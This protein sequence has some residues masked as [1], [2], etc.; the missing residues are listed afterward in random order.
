MTGEGGVALRAATALGRIALDR[1]D[2]LRGRALPRTAEQLA[3]PRM[4]DEL[5]AGSAPPDAPPLP[6]LRRAR[7][8]GVWFESSNCTNF[9]IEV[10]F[11]SA[12]GADGLRLP[13]TLYAKLPPPNV[14][15]RAFANAMGFWQAEVLFCRRLAARVPVATPRVYAAAWRGARFV[16]LLENLHERPGT[17]LFI[18]RDMAAGSTPERSRA[19]L[20]ALARLH[21]AFWST[22]PH[23]RDALL[24]MRLHA[25][26]APG[27]R[28]RSRALAE[29][30]IGPCHRKV[31]DLFRAEHVA[32]C[33]RALAKWDRLV[34]AWYAEPLTLLHGDSHLANCFEHPAT[35][36]SGTAVGL[37][38]FQGVHWGQGVRDVQYHLIDSL[39]P[40]VLAACER[41]LVDDYVAALARH[42]VTLESERALEQYRVLSFQTLVVAMV[43][44]GLGSLTEREDTVRT[45]LRRSVAA[46]ERLGFADRLDAL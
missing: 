17:R 41:T 7:L 20:E 45:V 15:T 34:D 25:H 27:A 19:C 46:I 11:E 24:P 29:A 42:G 39:E 3:D 31:P 32:L 13:R 16:L 40:D 35:D 1:V 23:E 8:P 21:A 33:R 18:N 38:D 28:A 6:R 5:L 9:L 37:L 30:A 44:L 43:S 10:E 12:V 2:E 4:L 22:P 26:L 14:A 36:G